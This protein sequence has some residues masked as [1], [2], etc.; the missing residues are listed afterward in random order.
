MNYRD[1]ATNV[2]RRLVEMIETDSHGNWAMPWHTHDVGDVLDARNP[3]TKT[4]YRGANVITLVVDALDRGFPT[5]HW[6]TYRQWAKHG[7]QVRKGEYGAQVIKWVPAP[8]EPDQEAATPADCVQRQLRPRVY[9][10]FN[11]HQVD[12][13][14]PQ[15]AS[16][17]T[18]PVDEW[19]TAI[20]ADVVYGSDRAYY[21]PAADRI[22]LPA[23]DQFDDME[24]FHATSLHE[25]IHWTGHSSR[26][27]RLHVT[28]RTKSAEYAT[29]EL[30]AELGAAIGCA[31]L[32]ISP[33]PRADHAQYLSYWLKQL[34]ADPTQLFRSAAAAQRALDH[35][36]ALATT[37]R[38]DITS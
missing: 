8:T 36:D 5:G 3:T 35:L 1:H 22:H 18:T 24:A 2:T 38:D 29:E 14:D 10:V 32:G 16:D 12:G 26:L 9:A 23:R 20:G 25:H 15:P 28:Q 30:V 34:N 17:R 33:A 19:F 6:A 21:E 37:Q 4:R 31:Q 7:A 13:H 11:A 27:G